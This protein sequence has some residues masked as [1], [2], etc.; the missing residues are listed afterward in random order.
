MKNIKIKDVLKIIEGEIIFG[1]ADDEIID[2]S[3][4]TRK[5]K[6]GDTFIAIKGETN[7]GNLYCNI[8]FESGARI[9]LVEDIKL[10]DTEIKKYNN[11]N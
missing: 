9:C 7:N 3:T 11:K 1:N 8:A 10:T 6:E 2:V 5:I 4:D